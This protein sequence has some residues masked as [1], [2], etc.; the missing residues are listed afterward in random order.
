MSD[1]KVKRYINDGDLLPDDR[2]YV[3]E[4]DYDQVVQERDQYKAV[5]YNETQEKLIEA[6]SN[7]LDQLRKQV[8]RIGNFDVY[9]FSGGLAIRDADGLV[10]AMHPMSWL[11]L[12]KQV[13]EQK[14]FMRHQYMCFV[15]D[16]PPGTYGI[17][18]TPGD[19]LKAPNCVCGLSA[20][21]GEG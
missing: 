8:L 7:E 14:Q 6:L 3:L 21:L 18:V 12:S 20:Y 11:E 13:E 17:G 1:P 16:T 15:I 19:P 4:S 10:T 2:T 5:A 9:E